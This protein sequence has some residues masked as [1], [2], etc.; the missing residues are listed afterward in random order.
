MIMSHLT[1]GSRCISDNFKIF[2]FVFIFF[3][4]YPMNF[5]QDPSK[6]YHANH[7]LLP[8]LWMIWVVFWIINSMASV[9]TFTMFWLLWSVWTLTY[10]VTYILNDIFT[11]VYWYRVSRKIIWTGF[12]VFFVISIVGYTYA[13]IPSDPSFL[14]N[15]EFDFF[16]KASP[17][18]VLTSLLAFSS[19]EFTNSFILAKMKI[20]TGGKYQWFRYILST[21]WGQLIDNSIFNILWVILLWWYTW[22]QFLSLTITVVL[23]CT[24][25]EIIALPITKKIIT[26]IKQKEWLDVYDIWTNF[27]P[28]S[29][30]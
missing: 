3:V 27:N 8:I 1:Q 9:K 30:K 2:S 4:I 24:L 7:K 20:Y 10:P 17:F 26:Y 5:I 14:Y 23:F 6:A 12:V 21:L 25:R 13:L 11:E 15:D 22:S 19:G 18:V 28:F 16:F 29:L